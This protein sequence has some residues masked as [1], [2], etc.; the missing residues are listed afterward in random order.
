M[1]SSGRRGVNGCRRRRSTRAK[2]SQDG[3][4][5]KNRRAPIPALQSA[6][7]TPGPGSQC[8]WPGARS[9]ARVRCASSRLRCKCGH[10]IRRPDVNRCASGALAALVA[11]CHREQG[12]EL[13][14]GRQV[15]GF[16]GHTIALDDGSRV[17]A[18][19]VVVGIGVIANDELARAADIACDDGIFVD[20][21]GRLQV[22]ADPVAPGSRG[23]R[24]LRQ[25]RAR[26]LVT[27]APARRRSVAGPHS[28]C[29]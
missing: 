11:R 8:Q 2:L 4:F 26:V 6:Y 7:S 10:Q 5:E 29:R 12:V 18:D 20:R 19:M 25:Q 16:S 23:R 22:L 3:T 17:E 28:T 27:Q 24:D 14:L 9:A 13:R 21:L 1:N 15:A